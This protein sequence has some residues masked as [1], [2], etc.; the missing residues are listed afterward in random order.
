LPYSS[1]CVGIPPMQG[2]HL[3]IEDVSDLQNQS[4]I[5]RLSGPL[6]L[7]TLPEF[8]SRVRAVLS[9]N[10]IFDMTDV[11]YV[12]S[13][14]IGVLVGTYVRHQRDE[15]GVCL[16]GANDRVQA[17]LKIAHVERF[18]RFFDSLV[19]VKTKRASGSSEN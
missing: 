12:D 7:T 17:A 11:P 14:G 2:R 3:V 1:P 8:Q 5:L 4:H 19:E 15:N 10:L 16:V 18:F 13:A 6:T 9:D